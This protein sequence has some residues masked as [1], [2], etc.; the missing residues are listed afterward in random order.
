MKTF[1]QYIIEVVTFKNN[2]SWV[3]SPG[4]FQ[5][6]K[7]GDTE[8]P[9]LFPHLD[10][11]G[12]RSTFEPIESKNK[13]I[14]ATSWGRVD[15]DNRIVH[16]ITQNGMV[17]PKTSLRGRQLEDDVFARLNGLKHLRQHFP[18]YRV[19]TAGSSY[20]PKDPIISHTYSEHEKHLM[21]MLK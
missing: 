8:H 15:H 11:M 13:K 21:D 10:F 20:N 18:D 2:S 1:K 4:G 9:D 7:S 19:H 17:S 6:K 3:L 5:I 16:I 12:R 14:A